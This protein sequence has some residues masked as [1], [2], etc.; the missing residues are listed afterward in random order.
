MLNKNMKTK[1][2]SPDGDTD[3]FDIVAG[4]LKLDTLALFPFTICLDYILQTSLDL[5][6]E[7]CSTLK[8]ANS[9]W[10]SAETITDAD[11]T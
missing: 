4:V 2:C 5:I 11:Y 1:V 7:N 6:K 8:K 9:R 3:F 10:Y